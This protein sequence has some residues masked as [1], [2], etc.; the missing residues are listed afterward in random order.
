[1]AGASVIVYKCINWIILN[2]VIFK[3]YYSF[4][5]F[6]VIDH[7]LCFLLFGLCN[8]RTVPVKMIKAKIILSKVTSAV[9]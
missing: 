1:M 6:N 5:N 8:Q 4:F 3:K 7:E 2:K 9:L